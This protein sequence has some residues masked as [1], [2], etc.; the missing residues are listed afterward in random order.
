[1]DILRKNKN[2]V[3]IAGII[4]VLCIAFM[5]VKINLAGNGDLI[6]QGNIKTEETDLNSKIPG[7]INQILVE[8]GQ[9]VK[10]G[11]TLIIIS[12]E[13]I[14]AKKQQAQ[15]AAAAAEAQYDKALN[16][17]RSQEVAQAKAAYDLAD[18][19]YQRIK[20]LYEQEA[21]SENTYDQVF[22]QYTAA[23]ETYEMAEQGAREEDKAAA[24]ALVEQA[25]AALVTQRD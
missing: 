1:M 4:I 25:R 11:D 10:K 19:T 22:A 15:A 24:E 3:I 6:I 18:K 14:E 12:S 16:G 17:A 13:A 21:I 8:E 2:L 5:V 7:N 9:E 20:K 23:K